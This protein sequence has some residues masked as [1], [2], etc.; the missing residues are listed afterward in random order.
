MGM[1]LGTAAYM[2]PEQAR[3]KPVDRRADIWAFG[4]VLYEMLT[5]KRAFEG[6]DVSITLASVLKEDPKWSV[7]P[8]DLPAPVV[9]LL[10]RCLEKEPKRRL[11]SISDARLELDEKEPVSTTPSAAAVTVARPSLISRVWPALVGVA[12]TPRL[13]SAMWPAATA[14]PARGGLERFSILAPPEIRSIRTLSASPFHPTARWWRSPSVRCL[15]PRPQ[16]W[17]RSL[18]SLTARRLEGGDGAALVFWSPDS[19]RIGF[20]TQGKLKTIA[21]TGGRADV[22]ADAPGPRGGV[23]TSSNEIIFARTPAARCSRFRR[24]VVRRRPSPRSIRL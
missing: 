9:R 22:L 20:L 23:W 6:D 12:L 15:D 18:D 1:I 14:T 11:S 17:V 5:G 4:V 16:L 8:P 7:L 21:R 3:G 19:K 24:T 10:R 2:S 13:R